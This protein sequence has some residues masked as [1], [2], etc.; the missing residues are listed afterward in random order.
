MRNYWYLLVPFFMSNCQV[1]NEALEID[2]QVANHL[3]AQ[4]GDAHIGVAGPLT[5]VLG[6]K[7]I[8]A[9]GANFPNG[10]PW[11]GGSKHY[12]KE[13]YVYKLEDGKVELETKIPF[14]DSLAYAANI[15][16]ANYL[17]SIGGE[18]NGIATTDVYRYALKDLQLVREA[19]PVLPIPLT[20][21][22]ASILNNS[23]YVIGGENADLVSDQIYELNLDE[24]VPVWK[25]VYTLPKAMSH[26]VVS[27]DNQNNIWIAGGRKRNANQRSDMYKEVYTFDVKKKEL[28]S[29]VDLPYAL[30]AGTALFIAPYFVLFGG[31]DA[32]T[33]HQVESLMGAINLEKDANKKDSLIQEKNS[34]Q[35]GHPGF[36]ST[37]WAINTEKKEVWRQW[38]DLKGESPV[39][40]TAL[41]HNKQIIIPSGEV[42]A[43]IR[44]NQILVG[45]IK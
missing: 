41:L 5:G 39:T 6:N 20:N 16:D 2:W 15:S 13:A 45:N 27:A 26:A 4:D 3:P 37:V 10:M 33:F 24:E 44:T 28:K 14:V 22:A 36:K 32:S 11:E 43:G 21:A 12:Q 25:A 1:N 9:G 23:I 34:L 17:Y 7:L 38:T 30:A 8:I 19:L 42:K 31:D 40:T 35:R 18:R 29:T